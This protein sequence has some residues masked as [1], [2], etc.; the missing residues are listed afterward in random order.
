MSELC[1]TDEPNFNPQI[2]FSMDADQDSIES[3]L[4]LSLRSVITP[5]SHANTLSDKISRINFQRAD[6]GGFRTLTEEDLREEIAEE[7]VAPT[8]GTELDSS[9]TE[10][11]DYEEHDRIKELANARQELLGQIEYAY[12]LPGAIQMLSEL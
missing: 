4:L 7:N 10:D 2:Q 11:D 9:A 6:I 3:D 1:P 12:Q 5:N 8:N